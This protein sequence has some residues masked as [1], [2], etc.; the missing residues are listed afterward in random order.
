MNHGLISHCVAH[1]LLIIET[2]ST[3][4]LRLILIYYRA[5][6]ATKASSITTCNNSNNDRQL[7]E[8]ER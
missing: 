1:G 5:L 7:I 4:E 8:T 6:M 2:F 3:F